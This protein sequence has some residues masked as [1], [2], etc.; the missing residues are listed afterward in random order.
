M[1]IIPSNTGGPVS[2]MVT[3]LEPGLLRQV[4][5]ALRIG[6]P[7][8][9]TECYQQFELERHGISRSAFFRYAARIRQLCDLDEAAER[10]QL[11]DLDVSGYLPTLFGRKL[12][13]IL[14]HEPDVDITRLHRLTLAYR[15]A[16]NTY[17]AF[18]DRKK[19]TPPADP[20]TELLRLKTIAMIHDHQD[21]LQRQMTER[22]NAASGL[23]INRS[24]EVE[25]GPIPANTRNPPRNVLSEISNLK[26]TPRPMHHDPTSR[27][28]MRDILDDLKQKRNKKEKPHPRNTIRVEELSPDP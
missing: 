1:S 16:S 5:Q 23:P 12:L 19:K 15:A 21:N 26:S 27:I 25:C 8:T 20:E 2:S 7:R 14:L 22:E 4:E 17:I 18:D 9:V 28:S 3:S 11:G 13:G 24:P 10:I 6:Q